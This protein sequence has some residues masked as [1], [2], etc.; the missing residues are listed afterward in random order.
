MTQRKWRTG[1]GIDKGLGRCLPVA[2]AGL[3]RGLLGNWRT[4]RMTCIQGT[5]KV[6]DRKDDLQGTRGL[7]RDYKGTRGTWWMTQKELG[8]L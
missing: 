8:D 5:E 1:S 3:E 2:S 6:L 7:E 4:G